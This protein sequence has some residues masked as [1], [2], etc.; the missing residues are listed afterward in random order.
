MVAVVLFAA[1]A[2]VLRMKIVPTAAVVF[3]TLKAAVFFSSKGIYG[4]YSWLILGQKR[5]KNCHL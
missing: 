2:F 3:C 4:I 5:S 1:P